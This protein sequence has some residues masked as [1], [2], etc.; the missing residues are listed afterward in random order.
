MTVSVGSATYPAD[1]EITSPNMMI[2]LADQALLRAKRLGRDRYVAFGQLDR[3]MRSELCS[4]F[5]LSRYDKSVSAP[6]L[7]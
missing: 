1:A 2:Y 4:Q 6:V 3:E 5:R 7:P